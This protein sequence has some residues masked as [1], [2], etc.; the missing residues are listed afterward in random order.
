M[1]R[2]LLHPH[3]HS[4][5]ASDRDQSDKSRKQ[6]DAQPWLSRAVSENAST[7]FAARHAIQPTNVRI[8]NQYHLEAEGRSHGKLPDTYWGPPST[9]VG[10]IF[11]PFLTRTKYRDRSTQ[12]S[13]L[14]VVFSYQSIQTATTRL[15]AFTKKA[16]RLSVEARSSLVHL[17]KKAGC[18]LDSA[19]GCW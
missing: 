18:L 10:H 7:P 1:P 14:S 5:P 9:Y 2:L 6:S 4:H 17:M 13:A 11:S 8:S 15:I 3:T 19:Q 12:D 16:L